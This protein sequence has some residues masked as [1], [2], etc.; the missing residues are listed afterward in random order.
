MNNEKKQKSYIHFGGVICDVIIKHHQINF[1]VQINAST[2][3]LNCTVATQK[4]SKKNGL[5]N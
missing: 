4:D 1:A 3:R 2:Y 5:E